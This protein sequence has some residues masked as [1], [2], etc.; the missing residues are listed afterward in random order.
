MG[1]KARACGSGM[2]AAPDKRGGGGG[3]A[4]G[5]GAA[6]NWYAEPESPIGPGVTLPGSR[7]PRSL[8]SSFTRS[9]YLPQWRVGL[10]PCDVS[11]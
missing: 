8:R 3:A 4:A 11:S 9:A 5:S 2:A 7:A 10:R 6:G 1:Y